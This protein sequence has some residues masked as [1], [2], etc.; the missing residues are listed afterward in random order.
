M[1][2]SAAAGGGERPED[3]PTTSDRDTPM[4]RRVGYFPVLLAF[5]PARCQRT[6]PRAR[7]SPDRITGNTPFAR[8]AEGADV[9]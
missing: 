1:L 3:I 8:N 4:L 2:G 7:Y 9:V 5:S 6:R